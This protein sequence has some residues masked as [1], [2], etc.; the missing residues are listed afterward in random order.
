MYETD[1]HKAVLLTESIDHL[2]IRPDG[3]YVDVTFGGGG[4]SRAILD[5]LGSSGH[6]F[7]FDQDPDA[8][9]NAPTDNRFTFVAANFRHLVRILDY[10]NITGQI[11]GILADLGVSSHQFDT[12]ERGFSFRANE[13]LADMRMNSRAGKTAAHIIMNYSEEQLADVF[14]HYGELH[15]SKRIARSIV[16]AREAGVAPISVGDLAEIA[17][18]HFSPRDEKSLLARLFQALRIEVN[19]EMGALDD[20][21]TDMHT[22]LAPGGRISII[23]YHSLED[24]R[25]KTALRKQSETTSN[26]QLIYGGKDLLWDVITRK[27]ISSNETEIM[28]NPRARSAKLRVARKI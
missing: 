11:D 25:V 8:I 12:A 1:Y 24:R 16:T 20:L 5:R 18:S 28:E 7:G 14:F 3:L 17:K 13:P 21:L 10:Y 6:L 2:D 15:Q 19:D 26:E 4:H 9:S 22:A 27:P 23:T